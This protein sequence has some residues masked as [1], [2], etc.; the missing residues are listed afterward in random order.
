MNAIEKLNA[1][2]LRTGTAV[3]A[4][5]E[6]ALDHLPALGFLPNHQGY[7]SF[8]RMFI[9]VTQDLVAAYKFNLAFFESLGVDGAR[10]LFAV[11]ELIPD[12]VLVIADAK[13]GDIGSTAKHYAKSL[14][15]VFAADS[16]TV[17]PLMGRDSAEPFLAYTN[18][19]TY[20]L[21]LTSN[22]GAADFLQHQQ[23]F[24]R[25]AASVQNWSAGTN[26]G[27]VVGATRAIDDIRL[28]RD[29]APKLPFLVPGV[30][31]QGGDA[32]SVFS[33][34]VSADSSHLAGGLLVHSTRGLLAGPADGNR[35]VAVVIREK[36][37]TFANEIRLA[38]DRV[39]V[40]AQEVKG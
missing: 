32:Q 36:T 4:G 2:I 16:A 1:A 6:P 39:G 17:N 18:K 33:A 40:S 23:L 31:A 20:F 37:I 12:H 34:G 11:R 3:S 24:E 19:L 13:R 28:V 5:I 35:D 21:G 7:L 14:Y 30:G 15:E 29:A 22:P 9:E 38:M 10:L 26:A 8:F 27:L 25:I